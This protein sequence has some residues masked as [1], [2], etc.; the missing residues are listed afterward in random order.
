MEKTGISDRYT[1]RFTWSEGWNWTE[2]TN[3]PMEAYP[4]ALFTVG[5]TGQTAVYDPEIRA[6]G[7][8]RISAWMP[9]E[10]N[11]PR[12]VEYEI[13]HSAAMDTVVLDPAADGGG[14]L[15]EPGNLFVLRRRRGVCDGQGGVGN[16]C[17][18]AFRHAF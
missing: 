2:E 14:R 3:S 15:A 7:Q 8:V 11:P 18:P 13:H 16:G 5:S 12:R 10:E 4:W 6:V 9:V 1:G 17:H